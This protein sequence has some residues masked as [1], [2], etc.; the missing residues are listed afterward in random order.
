MHTIVW[1]QGLGE[2][3][4]VTANAA[5]RGAFLRGALPSGLRTLRGLR[6]R[7]ASL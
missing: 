5:V 6:E 2:L 7:A 4:M 3:G 1:K